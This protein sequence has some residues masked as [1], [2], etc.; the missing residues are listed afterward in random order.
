MADD[1]YFLS[2]DDHAEMNS[3]HSLKQESLSLKHS[4]H[5]VHKW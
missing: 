4:A 5:I 1:L 2:D 3:K